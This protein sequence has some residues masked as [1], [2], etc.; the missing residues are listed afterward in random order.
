MQKII[1]S[2]INLVYFLFYYLLDFF[3]KSNTSKPKI[4]STIVIEL[5]AL[6]D[7]T[8]KLSNLKQFIAD[9]DN[10]LIICSIENE[11]IIKKSIGCPTKGINKS[12]YLRNPFYRVITNNKL[13]KLK[14]T[15]AINFAYTRY[16]FADDWVCKKIN[17][18]NKIGVLGDCR[19]RNIFPISNKWYTKIIN[20]DLH[21]KHITEINKDI[22]S[23]ISGI[24]SDEINNFNQIDLKIK[25]NLF[26]F[27]NYIIVFPG[28]GN[29][30]R[31]LPHKK[32]TAV[33]EKIPK[34]IQIIIAGSKN[35]IPISQSI[36]MQLDNKTT[37]D[38]TGK[39][40]I[41][42]SI[43]LIKNSNTLICN[44]SAPLHIAA[45]YNIETIC[46][47]GGGHFGLFAPYPK[48]L[49]PNANFISAS[50]MTCFNCNW[51]CI[52]KHTQTWPCVDNISIENSI[53]TIMKIINSKSISTQ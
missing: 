7:L 9:I 40:T 47:L 48:L 50:E 30:K 33:L 16:I 31:N 46:F 29:N 34:D 37:I 39:T 49:F 23:S 1:P 26:N 51:H 12:K 2:T 52:Y 32:L 42:E 44:E 22:F 21:N 10:T 41:E 13:C 20:C 24:S 17:A 3:C 19:T 35:D 43:W 14:T 18:K 5:A 4:Y 15:T 6:G 8:I 11:E 27:K 28:S 38:L 36:N 53:E 45:L 25:K